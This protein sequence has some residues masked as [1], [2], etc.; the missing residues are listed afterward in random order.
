VHCIWR[1]RLFARPSW[2]HPSSSVGNGEAV[3]AGS[4]LASSHSSSCRGRTIGFLGVIHVRR[5]RSLAAFNR[6][7]LRSEIPSA[8]QNW[9]S[10]LPPLVGRS[11]LLIAHLVVRASGANKKH[12]SP[13]GLGRTRCVSLYGSQR[14]CIPETP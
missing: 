5:G 11:L 7:R 1:R 14:A 3:G 4:V 2:L 12:R 10:D 9:R 6:F 8:S 13:R